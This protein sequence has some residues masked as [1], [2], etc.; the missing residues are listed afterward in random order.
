MAGRGLG[1]CGGAR[2]AAWG[3]GRGAG[4]GQGRGFGPG[5]SFG[6][7][8]GWFSVGYGEGVESRTENIKAALEERRAFLRAELERTDSLLKSAGGSLTPDE[9]AGK[10]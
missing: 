6:R 5:M 10:A 7:G 4:R 2:A 9:D 8:L 3:L 1:V